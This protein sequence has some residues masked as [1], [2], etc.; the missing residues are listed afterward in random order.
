MEIKIYES[1]CGWKKHQWNIRSRRYINIDWILFCFL[2]LI[3]KNW[4]AVVGWTI[5][6]K[7]ETRERLCSESE[8][9]AWERSNRQEYKTQCDIRSL[10]ERQWNFVFF[11]SWHFMVFFGND[12]K[13]NHEW[14]VHD[15]LKM[16]FWHTLIGFFLNFI[17]FVGDQIRGKVKLSNLILEIT[18]LL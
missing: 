5:L 16:I 1:G 13:W 17:L 12:K 9:P 6:Q 3:H 15:F 4:N 2:S 11:V 14:K 7:R 8:L 18:G 10:Y